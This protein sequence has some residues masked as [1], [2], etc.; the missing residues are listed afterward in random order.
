MTHH[1]VK[2][3]RLDH[4]DHDGPFE[5]RIDWRALERVSGVQEQRAVRG[6]GSLSPF[7]FRDRFEPGKTTV[8]LAG[9]SAAI[10][11][12][13]VDGRE[14][15]VHVVRVQHEQPENL[16]VIAITAVATCGRG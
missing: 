4:T 14:T 15:S 2:S 7:Q 8:T 6:P 12:G 16:L 13:L 1:D 10:R 11:P 9:M 5:V 3:E